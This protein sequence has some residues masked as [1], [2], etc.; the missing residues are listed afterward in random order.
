MSP[1]WVFAIL[2][3]GLG[4]SA[5]CHMTP[6]EN[7]AVP[8]LTVKDTP[9]PGPFDYTDRSVV[10]EKA[11][12]KRLA[13]ARF[14]DNIPVK[15]SP[16]GRKEQIDAVGHGIQLHR[17]EILSEENFVPFQFTEKL[18]DA[19]S[20]TR[21]FVLIER[22][23]INSL[24]RE[25]SFGE[26]R[27]V[28]KQ[29]SAKLGK[30][31]GA[32]IIVTGA[33]SLNDEP[34]T[35]GGQPLL[36]LLRMYDVET[37]R[38]VGTARTTGRTVQEVIDLAVGEIVQTMDKVPWTGKI[39]SVTGDQAY[40]NAGSQENVQIGDRFTLFSLGGQ[41]VDPDSKEV[42]GYQEEPAGRAEVTNVSDRVATL[43]ILDKTRPLKAGD[44]AQPFDAANP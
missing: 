43:K 19:L 17:E 18:L 30:I 11:L 1:R 25:V 21:R 22:K 34:A 35:R 14:D 31:L 41:I 13:V 36:L 28:D 4:L 38:I 10:P 20:Q 33:L 12:R 39:A 7:P 8:P 27:W 5:A 23:D 24:L 44:K 26:T 3:V 15:D 2:V 16:F 40:L 9:V 32:Q 6:I 37:S 29:K 42:I